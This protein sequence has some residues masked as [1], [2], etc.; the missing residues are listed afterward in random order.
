MRLRVSSKIIGDHITLEDEEK[1][2]YT[3]PLGIIPSAIREGLHKE[4][5]V[6]A[7]VQMSERGPL[8][9]HFSKD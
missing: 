8:V 9:N 3:I 4:S 2:T 5:V 6:Y 1:T 7:D